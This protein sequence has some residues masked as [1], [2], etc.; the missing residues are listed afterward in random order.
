MKTLNEVIKNNIF[1]LYYGNRVLLP[2]ATDLL[3]AVVE[4][5]II[6]DF[7]QHKHGSHYTKYDNYTEVY[8]YDFKNLSDVV[9]KYETIKLVVVEEG[10]DIFDLKNHRKI[11]LHIED[12]HRLRIEECDDDIL[13]FE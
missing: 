11:A 6:T 8:F 5:D 9:S 13:F 2:F 7:S 1:G 10:K 3:K 4:H 12:E